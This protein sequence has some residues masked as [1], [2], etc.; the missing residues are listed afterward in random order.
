[1]SYN[2]KYKSSEIEA[3]LDSVEG[4]QDN[5][6]SGTNIK[7]INGESIL[8]TGDITIKERELEKYATDKSWSIVETS[9]QELSAEHGNAPEGTKAIVVEEVNS[10]YGVNLSDFLMGDV[11]GILDIFNNQNAYTLEISAIDTS[12][13][14]PVSITRD[15]R[16]ELP[17]N[18]TI[19][20]DMGADMASISQISVRKGF[21]ESVWND[22]HWIASLYM[23]GN[24]IPL[25][26][27]NTLD[28]NALAGL[29]AI[30]PA[31][32]VDFVGTKTITE[33][34]K[35]GDNWEVWSEGKSGLNTQLNAWASFVFQNI[36]TKTSQLEND[37]NFVSSDGLKTINGESILGSG[38]IEIGGGSSVYVWEIDGSEGGTFSQEEFDKMLSADIIVVKL[39]ANDV[40]QHLVAEHLS[41]TDT[42]TIE[43]IIHTYV[44]GAVIAVKYIVSAEG[45]Q[46]VYQ[47]VYSNPT[48]VSDL[49]NDSNFVSSNGLKTINGESIVGSGDIEISGGSGGKE[50]VEAPLMTEP[51]GTSIMFTNSVPL[52]P[53]KVYVAKKKVAAVNLS[54]I[55]IPDDSIGY[56]YTIM[57][58]SS[59]S[60][61]SISGT[62]Q[63]LWANGTIPTIEADTYYELSLVLNNINNTLIL[64]AAL[65]PFKQVE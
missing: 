42:N 14:L 64:K 30:A 39:T 43:L 38:N 35:N 13:E 40:E 9:L 19:Y 33:Y 25:S 60:E 41:N 56:E 58:Q 1:M 22:G 32:I 15:V 10:L 45:W 51:T 65:T 4:K 21:I 53:N 59:T 36:P 8:G 11:D 52:E 27:L 6:V 44:M 16:V 50:Y 23:L 49:E 20:I 26:R 34:V 31:L 37:S 5:L 2:S 63:M 7:T 29:I 17:F 12:V 48:K 46:L 54:P 62:I 24:K 3:I 57:F 28:D 61:L 55:S 47:Y 18:N